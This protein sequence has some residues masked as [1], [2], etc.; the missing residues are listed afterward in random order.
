MKNY[1]A[2]TRAE[3]Y[4]RYRERIDNHS[5]IAEQQGDLYND[6]TK[7][8]PKHNKGVSTLTTPK[9]EKNVNLFKI[10]QRN[11]GF[12]IFLYV[13]LDLVAIALVV[14]MILLIGNTFLGFNLW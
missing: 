1:R 4:K 5:F 9:K 12:R 8:E 11:R 6:K 3:K 10:Y 13:L 2:S 14:F 7:L